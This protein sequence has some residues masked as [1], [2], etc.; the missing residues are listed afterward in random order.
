VAGVTALFERALVLG[1]F[2]MAFLARRGC[3]AQAFTGVAFGASDLLMLT[4]QCVPHRCMIET[5]H[6]VRTIVAPQ[7]IGAKI[8]RVFSREFL[9]LVCMACEAGLVIHALVAVV[10]V[11]FSTF[12]GRRIEIDLVVV[13]SETSRAVIEHKECSLRRVEITPAVVWVAGRAWFPLADLAVDTL[14][15]ADLLGHFFMAF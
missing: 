11:A 7:A 1:G 9:V 12:H 5:D 13:Q 2:R 14:S 4:I 10:L 15:S 8:A 6:P 3:I